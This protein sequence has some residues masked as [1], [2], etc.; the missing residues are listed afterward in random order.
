MEIIVT[1]VSLI[2]FA[3]LF[4]SPII[5]LKIISKKAIKYKFFIYLTFGILIS[6][7]LI[8]VLAW[9]KV[10]SNRLL[11]IHYGYNFDGL[12]DEDYFK[13]VVPENK[14]KVKGLLISLMGIGWPV[15]A[16]MSIVF[17][18]PYLVTIY[19][20]SFLFGKKIQAKINF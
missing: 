12:N 2:F 3:G 6:A 17:F 9:W 11:L 13:K 5:L 14:Q 15:K 4:L 16:I 1:G 10:E 8:F 19:I 18:F 20:G 7:I